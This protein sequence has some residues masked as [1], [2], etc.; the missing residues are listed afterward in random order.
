MAETTDELALVER[1]G[2]LLHATH[3]D[4]LFVHFEEAVFGN[5]DVKTRGVGVM[6]PERVFMKLDGEWSRAILWYWLCE[7]CRVGRGL[8]R[9]CK[10]LIGSVRTYVDKKRFFYLLTEKRPVDFRGRRERSRARE[11]MR[12]KGGIEVERVR[13]MSC[14]HYSLVALWGP[15]LS[16]REIPSPARLH[17]LASSGFSRKT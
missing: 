11:A 2:R 5:L 14:C 13:R 8:Q 1:I 9:A 16:T 3:G 7:L 6:T 17:S 10:P 12:G 4:H 15:V